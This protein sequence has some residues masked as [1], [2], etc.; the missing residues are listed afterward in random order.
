[1][2]AQVHMEYPQN[3]RKYSIQ[4][5]IYYEMYRCRILCYTYKYLRIENMWCG[6]NDINIYNISDLCSFKLNMTAI[7]LWHFTYN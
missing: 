7:N 3:K 1:M 2:Q 6:Y 5:A 4:T